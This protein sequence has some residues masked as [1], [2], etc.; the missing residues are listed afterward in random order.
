MDKDN[1]S[2]IRIIHVIIVCC[3]K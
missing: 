2:V 1:S 3:S